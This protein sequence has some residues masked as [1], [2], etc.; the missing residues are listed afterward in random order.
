MQG[1]EPDA[2][3]PDQP[4]RLAA[5]RV[6]R[7][8]VAGRFSRLL[9]VDPEDVSW[10]L[11]RYDTSRRG[12][13]WVQAARWKY[14]STGL[15]VVDVA[16]DMEVVEL[17][18][19]TS[20]TANELL[21]ST[22]QSLIG[23]NRFAL[24]GDPSGDWFGL[25]ADRCVASGD[26]LAAERSRKDRV[27]Q[28]LISDNVARLGRALDSVSK[29]IGPGVS[30]L[31][32]WNA[33]DE[34]LRSSKDSLEM[35]GNLASGL[36][37]LESDPHATDRRIQAGEPVL[38]DAYPRIGGYHADL[39]RTWAC[40]GVDARL[41]EAYAAVLASLRAVARRLRPGAVGG[42]LDRVARAALENRGQPGDFP[43]H[44]GHGFGVKQQEP[45][46]L[47]PGSTDVI[48]AECV[49]AVEPACYI[50][51][52]G[53]VRLEQDFLVRDDVTLEMGPPIA[54]FTLTAR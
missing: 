9:V 17:R 27:E 13:L 28:A 16:P 22:L 30:E 46:W 37:T 29:L 19:R 26:V 51:G 15:D 33:V 43:H 12:L 38:L 35:A 7:E 44:T 6:R 49:V 54:S 50:N 4:A 39:T 32:L 5:A 45:P 14:L 10:L 3:R 18:P 34:Q 24:A 2:G 11:G 40:G 42:D 47:R 25:V 31:D 21:G 8:R 41:Q 20:V 53:G 1:R 52:L 23:S 36:R 48:E